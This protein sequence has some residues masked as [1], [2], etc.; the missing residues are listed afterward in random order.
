M[1]EASQAG[2]VEISPGVVL[3]TTSSREEAHRIAQALITE[4]LAACVNLYPITSVYRWEGK[5]CNDEEIQLVI[6]TDLNR[7]EQLQARITQLHSYELPEI[8]ALPITQGASNYLH[9]MA[10]QLH[11]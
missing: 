1:T 5:V 3:T 6:K 7:F 2:A 9:W 8:I 11:I 4:H 10:A